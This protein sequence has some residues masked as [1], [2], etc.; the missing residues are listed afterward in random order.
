MNVVML[1]EDNE[2]SASSRLLKAGYNGKY[3]KFSGG[4]NKLKNKLEESYNNVDIFIV[5]IDVAPNNPFTVQFYES[6]LR[7]DY[8]KSRPNIYVVPI[9]CIEYYLFWS[10]YE[11]GYIKCNNNST[12]IAKRYLIDEPNFSELRMHFKKRSSSIEKLYKIFFDKNPSYNNTMCMINGEPSND[13][14]FY[15][16]IDCKSC[17]IKDCPLGCNDSLSLKAERLYTSLPV[18]DVVDDNHKCLLES[19]DISF[20]DLSPENLLCNLQE[21]YTNI[22]DVFDFP[23]I[24]VRLNMS[25]MYSTWK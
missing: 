2:K 4:Y 9:I 12:V 23:P 17:T 14:G 24:I 8:V 15:Y 11:L 10:V 18:F 20:K 13:M 16:L 3:I 22:C 19:F 21:F 7:H 5:F 25:G 6:F 1:F